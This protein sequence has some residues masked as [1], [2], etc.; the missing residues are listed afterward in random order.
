[1]NFYRLSHKHYCGVDLHSRTLCLCIV[2]QDGVVLLHRTCLAT[3][4][5]SSW[6]RSL[7]RGPRRRRRVRL[8]WY[9]LG[10]LCARAGITIVLGYALYMKA[11][12]GAKA[13]SDRIDF[14]KIAVLVRGGLMRVAYA[15]P[16][17]SNRERSRRGLQGLD[18]R[19]SIAAAKSEQGRTVLTRLE[20]KYGKPKALSVLAH[21]LGRAAHYMLARKQ[22]FD[23][24]RFASS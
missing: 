21:K 15:Y 20:R 9:W 1:M 7:P 10:D 22:A 11:I 8:R 13:K 5:D 24:Q 2:G 18:L 14:E 17:D 12:P 16:A 4:T 23:P 19:H 3:R 6:H